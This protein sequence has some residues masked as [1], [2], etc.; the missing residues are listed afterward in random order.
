MSSKETNPRLTWLKEKIKLALEPYMAWVRERYPK[1]RYFRFGA[2]K[3]KAGGRAQYD[4][5]GRRV[6]CDFDGTVHRLP[7]DERPVSFMVA[8]DSFDL[9][10]LENPRLPDSEIETLHAN[11]H[12]GVMFTSACLHSGGANLTDEDK[13]RLFA[14]A[15]SCPEDLPKNHIWLSDRVEDGEMRAEL[16]AFEEPDTIEGIQAEDIRQPVRVSK[17]GRTIFETDHF[18]F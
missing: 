18:H 6:H 4:L 16:W 12:A 2:I 10:F 13:Y 5:H 14:Y 9:L 15:V 3:T 17:R 8:L 7:P 11:K 1:L